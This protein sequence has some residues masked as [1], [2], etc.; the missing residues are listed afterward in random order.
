M[1]DAVTEEEEWDV[2]PRV[3]GS[4][5]TAMMFVFASGGGIRYAHGSSQQV[6]D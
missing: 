1:I 3:E 2:F 5:V 6:K 4:E